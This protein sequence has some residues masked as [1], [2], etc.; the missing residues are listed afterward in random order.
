[1]TN[2]VKKA[3]A[4]PPIEL[5]EG[6]SLWKDAGRRLRKNRAA[7]AGAVIVGFM[8]IAALGYEFVAQY[9]TG[10]TL[11]EQHAFVVP[12]PPGAR[13]VPSVHYKL[14]A[15]EGNLSFESVD[16]NGDGVIDDRE[17]LQAY[18][19]I[20]FSKIDLNGDGVLNYEEYALAPLSM[21]VPGDFIPACAQWANIRRSMAPIR[22][23]DIFACDASVEGTITMAQ[24]GRLLDIISIGEARDIINRYDT[25]R[26]NALDR[27]EYKGLPGPRVN[28][29]G[30]DQLGRDLLTRMVYGARIS[31]A[32]G[33][34]ATLVSFLI[35]VS[36]GA[37]AGF[38]G[39]KVD[40][41]MMRI[42][43]IMYGL[44]FMF[45]VILLMVVFGHNIFLLFIAL[46]AVQ[47]LTMARIVRGQV[48][49]LKGQ[50]FVEAARTIGV[51]NRAII[52]RH[53]IPNALGPIIVY[54]TLTVP[55]VMLEEA[56]LS[57]LGLGV[58]APMTSWGALA[59]EG[60]QLMETAPWLIVFPGL[61]LAV[62]LL[63]LNFVGDGLR[64]AL[65]PQLRKD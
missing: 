60:R 53:L 28:R 43:D 41:A 3:G 61:A 17:I 15:P 47:W 5:I 24:S 29:L 7:M 39:G 62:T 37:T 50:E 4:K 1:M 38:V 16:A 34:L 13:S 9:V 52:F 14:L 54:A 21:K 25:D 58:Q 44:P 33:L 11:A 10:F 22:H 57:F 18:R 8:A 12:K 59:S 32:V 6:T 23:P 20:E 35:G 63:S 27:R 55:A 64:D 46:G 2:E 30:T 42:V 65:D 36:W 26:D 40:N 19:Q 49:S 45:L 48:I 51:S 31:L 56:F